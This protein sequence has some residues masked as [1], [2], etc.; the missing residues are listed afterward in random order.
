MQ[1][2]EMFQTSQR[3]LCPN[4]VKPASPAPAAIPLIA[5]TPTAE[6]RARV[7]A[8]HSPGLKVHLIHFDGP[9]NL[10]QQNMKT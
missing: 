6:L 3:R 4:T 2:S 1:L 7:T 8:H 10:G 9:L 5:K